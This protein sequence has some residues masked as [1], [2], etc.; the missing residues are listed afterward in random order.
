MQSVDHLDKQMGMTVPARRRVALVTG[1]AS[2]LGSKFAENFARRGFDLVLVDRQAERVR[3]FANELAGKSG[4][5]VH[6]IPQDLCE[7]AAAANVQAVCDAHS[8]PI[9][10][11]V[12]NAGFPLDRPVHQ[13]PWD[14][15]RDNLHLLLDVVVEMCHRFLPAMIDRRWGRIIN[16]SSVS[17]LMPGGA[18]LATYNASKA[19]MIAFSEALSFELAGSGVQ[20]AAVCPGFMRTEIFQSSGL[21]DIRDSVPAFM[22]RDPARVAE[23]AI[24]AVMNGVPV[25]VS[26]CAN[27]LLVAVSKVVPRALL[28]QRTR[29]LHAV[30]H[31]SRPGDSGQGG[32][33]GKK[34]ALIT[35]A[36]SGIGASFCELLAGQGFD[37]VLVARRGEILRRRAQELSERYG[38]RAHVLLQDLS[39]PLAVRNI[40]VECERLGWPIE[41]LVNNAGRQ[42]TKLF[43][44]MSWAE[45]DGSL[46]LL[47]KSVVGLTHSFV[48]QMIERGSGKVINVA[49]MAAFQP[50]TYRSSLYTSSK[51]FVLG[52]SESI[53]A[54]LVGTG[55]TVTALCP[56]FTKTEWFSGGAA[57]GE[58]VPKSFWMESDAVAEIGL[59]AAQRGASVAVA[60]T[61]AVH[62]LY[63]LFSVGPRH[64]VGAV[65]SRKRK[66]LD[67]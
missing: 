25:R 55:V 31:R 65:L 33:E 29:I 57:G 6:A 49:S 41:V 47:V 58:I 11:L 16:V 44:Q 19:F 18:R 32:G 59:R 17:G 23:D 48:P 34:A 40:V 46:S 63:A 3:E 42:T 52:F 15:V 8:C 35:G 22:W 54:D 45:I 61:P 51:V 26:G 4:I 12:N 64:L 21:A 56:G 13:L 10:F 53:A 36:S 43:H 27:R 66:R 1:A 50:G 5:R 7:P 2:G 60:A 20:I 62:A 30:S 38:I 9:D 24:R 37:I 28:R 39:Q 67:V 14:A